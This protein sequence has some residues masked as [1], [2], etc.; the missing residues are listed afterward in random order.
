M[1]YQFF[2]DE[3]L[4][5]VTPSKIAIDGKNNNKSYTLSDGK[6]INITKVEG[7]KTFSFEAL[8][9][10][11]LY[12]FASYLEIS[13]GSIQDLEDVVIFDDETREKR[14]KNFKGAEYYLNVLRKLKREGKVFRFIITKPIYNDIKNFMYRDTN[15]KV[16]LED[17]SIVEDAKN[18]LDV[19]VNITLKEYVDFTTNKQA[20][21]KNTLALGDGDRPSEKETVKSYTVVKNDTLWGICKNILGDSNRY[22]EIAKL[23]GISNPNLI[24]VGQVIKFE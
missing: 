8:L 1:A 22:L 10:N 23:N 20:V 2:L 12:P 7:L 14:Q 18:G 13:N 15:L 3:I 24:Y 5:P 11:V 9:P 19:L 4:L 21:D 17:Y 6:E 16:T